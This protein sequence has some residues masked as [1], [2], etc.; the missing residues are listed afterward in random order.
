VTLAHAKVV[1]A[2]ALA[3]IAWLFG[4]K[5]A[6][7]RVVKQLEIDDDVYSDTFGEPVVQPNADMARLINESDAAI[8]AYD[9]T[10]P[11]EPSI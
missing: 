1:T 9:A 11:P 5:P 3:L 6:A 7:R 2:G 4:D 10:H 8:R